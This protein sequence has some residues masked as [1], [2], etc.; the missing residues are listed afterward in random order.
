MSKKCASCNKMRHLAHECW[1]RRNTRNYNQSTNNYQP[2]FP[3]QYMITQAQ[4][5]FPADISTYNTNTTN[6]GQTL[7]NNNVLPTDRP[8]RTVTFNTQNSS[9]NISSRGNINRTE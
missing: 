1:S 9:N 3:Q 7:N 5:Q 6:N 8:I 2:Q 4:N